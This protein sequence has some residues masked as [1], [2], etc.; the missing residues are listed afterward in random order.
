M[1]EELIMWLLGIGI[2]GY[3]LY[4]VIENG[5]YLHKKYQNNR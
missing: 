5:L 4:L 1:I 2:V 3:I